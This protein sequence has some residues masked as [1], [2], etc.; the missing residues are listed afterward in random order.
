MAIERYSGYSLKSLGEKLREV[1]DFKKVVFK[2]GSASDSSSSYEVQLWL[3]DK[4]YLIHKFDAL[5]VSN[6]KLDIM[7]QYSVYKRLIEG[8]SNSTGDERPW[9]IYKSDNGDVGFQI[10]DSPLM[11]IA[12]TVT[13]EG[14]ESVGL[15]YSTISSSS[16]LTSTLWIDGRNNGE[17]LTPFISGN[18][19]T[20]FTALSN[21]TCLSRDIYFPHLKSVI[22]SPLTVD[23]TEQKII[24]DGTTY[25]ANKYFALE[26]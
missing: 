20:Y 14:I 12:K 11:W 7:D 13:S 9:R 4:I 23:S 10:N 16:T 8:S 26:E 1:Y 6:C 5:S 22:F 15:I 21:A 3:T 2:S 25:I 17:T 19:S 18:T 24:I